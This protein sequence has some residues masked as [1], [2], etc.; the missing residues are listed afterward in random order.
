MEAGGKEES[1]STLNS[2]NGFKCL[3]KATTKNK[4]ERGSLQRRSS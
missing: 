1:R 3:I 2:R 4:K